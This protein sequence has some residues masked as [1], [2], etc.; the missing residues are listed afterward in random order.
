MIKTNNNAKISVNFPFHCKHTRKYISLKLLDGADS[1][2]NIKIFVGINI[3]QLYFLFDN[4]YVGY[5]AA[6]PTHIFWH[7]M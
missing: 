3:Q 5:A 1:F 4:I 7:L 2:K 6:L